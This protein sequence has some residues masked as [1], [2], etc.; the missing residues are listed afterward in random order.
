[1]YVLE[2]N[3]CAGDVDIEAASSDPGKSN[4]HVTPQCDEGPTAKKQKLDISEF[5]KK[6]DL[7]EKKRCNG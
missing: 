3:R 7:T 2:P 4:S 6:Y 5:Y 1:L